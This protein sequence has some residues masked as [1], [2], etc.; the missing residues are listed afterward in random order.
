MK[1]NLP[2][3]RKLAAEEAKAAAKRSLKDAGRLNTSDL[4]PSHFSGANCYLL[5]ALYSNRFQKD[6][7]K[8][9]T[10]QESLQTQTSYFQLQR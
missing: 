2:M 8:A 9:A 7:Q 1:R 4:K 10:M 5:K 3:P 6:L